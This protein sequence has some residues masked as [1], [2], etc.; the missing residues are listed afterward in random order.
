MLAAGDVAQAVASLAGGGGSS[1]KRESGA[2]RD[3]GGT[4]LVEPGIKCDRGNAAA[5]TESQP[6]PAS[7]ANTMAHSVTGRH[8]TACSAFAQLT[9]GRNLSGRGQEHVV[10]AVVHGDGVVGALVDAH[11]GVLVAQL[12]VR[13]L[14]QELRCAEAGRSTRRSV[15]LVPLH[16]QAASPEGRLHRRKA[17]PSSS[18]GSRSSSGGS[19]SSSGGS[20]STLT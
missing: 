7:P 9:H 18:G 12:G 5:S 4:R 2:C 15:S 8:A 1:F 19:R 10:D 13:L 14:E 16:A 3:G 11:A 6:E 20:R 17:G